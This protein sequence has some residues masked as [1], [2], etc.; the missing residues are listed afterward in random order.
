MTPRKHIAPGAVVWLLLGAA[1]FVISETLANV[2]KYAQATRA[3]VRV[4]G[5]GDHLSIEV[6]D[7]GIGGA[8]PR[9]GSG[10]RGLA[11]RLAALDGTISVVSPVGRGTRIS[12]VIPLDRPAPVPVSTL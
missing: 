11:D 9:S 7:D 3:I 6:E 5:L 2:A 12:A 10:L 8:D 4:R 1:Y